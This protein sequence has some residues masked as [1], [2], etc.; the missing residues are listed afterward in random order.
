M[1]DGKD[2]VIK[3][4]MPPFYGLLLFYT[5]LLATLATILF[6]YG[7]NT[8]FWTHCLIAF[9]CF[10]AS[11]LLFS[12]IHA[13]ILAHTVYVIEDRVIKEVLFGKTMDE[14]EIAA[15]I[16]KRIPFL[17]WQDILLNKD[18]FWF[19]QGRPTY[20]ALR[21]LKP[22]LANAMEREIRLRKARQAETHV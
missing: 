21:F 9:G 17:V 11:L 4:W 10:L 14:I 13:I 22:S 8:P 1:V 3:P 6:G 19:E 15:C 5:L 18:Y 2:T 20:T 7:I 16:P 12:T